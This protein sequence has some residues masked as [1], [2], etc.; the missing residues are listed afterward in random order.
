MPNERDVTDHIRRQT[1]PK[2]KAAPLDYQRAFRADLRD[3]RM[4]TKQWPCYNQH[5]PMRPQSNMHGAWRHCAVCNLR[6]C[7]ASGVAW[8]DDQAGQPSDDPADV[9]RTENPSSGS[10][11]ANIDDMLSHAKEIDAEEQ[12]NKL[13]RDHEAEFAPP[14]RTTPTTTPP[15]AETP[16][17]AQSSPAESTTTGSL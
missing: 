11:E 3:P 16:P 4:D 2:A 1:R 8:P 13:I 14:R 5:V 10:G 15:N 9:G 6:I 7:P 12:L 17:T